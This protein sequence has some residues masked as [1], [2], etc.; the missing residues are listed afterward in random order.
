MTLVSRLRFIA[1]LW[2]TANFLKVWCLV[3]HC[4]G[5]S[6]GISVHN[7]CSWP[8]NGCFKNR[9]GLVLLINVLIYFVTRNRDTKGSRVDPVKQ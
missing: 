9:I 6:R 7:L 2:L 1:L 5:V 8:Q 3:P 4:F